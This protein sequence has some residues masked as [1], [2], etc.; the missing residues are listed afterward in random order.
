MAKRR[1][2]RFEKFPLLL[3]IIQS[4]HS[5]NFRLISFEA[6]LIS[7]RIGGFYPDFEVVFLKDS[8]WSY[9]DSN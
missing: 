5:L 4:L 3:S 2:C 9:L 7:G 6:N 8:V 1:F